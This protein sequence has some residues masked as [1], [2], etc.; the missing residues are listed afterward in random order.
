M[1]PHRTFPFVLRTFE[2]MTTFAGRHA[3]ESGYPPLVM[4]S[5]I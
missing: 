2:A 3:G 1:F 5:H 4:E